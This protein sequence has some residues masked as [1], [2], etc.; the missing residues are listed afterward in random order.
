VQG[1]FHPE[2]F[3]RLGGTGGFRHGPSVIARC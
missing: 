1:K 3:Q 2:L